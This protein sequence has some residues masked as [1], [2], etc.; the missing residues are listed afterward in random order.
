M[1][2]PLGIGGDDRKGKPHATDLDDSDDDESDS[3]ASILSPRKAKR[4]AA[5]KLKGALD[6]T[7]EKFDA[8]MYLVKVHQNTVI[9]DLQRGKTNVEVKVT[10]RQK[11]LEFLVKDN[12][13][14][15]MICKDAVDNIYVTISGQKM[16]NSAKVVDLATGE[17]KDLFN[18]SRAVFVPLLDRQVEIDRIK[19][20]LGILKR[21]QFIFN[22]PRRMR[23]NIARG[24][25]S[26]VVLNYK[27]VRSLVATASHASIKN[28]VGEVDA[29]V[30]ELHTTLFEDLD[31]P[32]A[33]LRQQEESIKLLVDLGSPIDPAWYALDLRHSRMKAILIE[34]ALKANPVPLESPHYSLSFAAQQ[35]RNTSSIISTVAAILQEHMPQ[36][37]QLANNFFSRSYHKS[38][39]EKKKNAL[40]LK[41]PLGDFLTKLHEIITLFSDIVIKAFYGNTARTMEEA[42][43]LE[44]RFDANPQLLHHVL[45]VVAPT[46]PT[47]IVTGKKRKT[48]ARTNA[49]RTSAS[50]DAAVMPLNRQFAHAQSEAAIGNSASSSSNSSSG[51]APGAAGTGLSQ[52]SGVVP[53]GKN[54]QNAAFTSQSAAQ[55]TVPKA[56]GTIIASTTV[57]TPNA[58]GS[59]SLSFL[60]IDEPLYDKEKVI[61]ILKLYQHLTSISPSAWL[62]PLAELLDLVTR[63]FVKEVFADVLMEAKTWYAQ[64]DWLV[65]DQQRMI[66]SLPFTF[67]SALTSTL[68]RLDGIISPQDPLLVF[69]KKRFIQCIECY[70]D[71]IHH[72]AFVNVDTVYMPPAIRSH[73]STRGHH[74]NDKEEID[75]DDEHD[76]FNSGRYE[77]PTLT[78]DARLLML[79]NN[80]IY[81]KKHI[82]PALIDKFEAQYGIPLYDARARDGKELLERL[83]DMII[84]K[85]VSRKTRILNEVIRSGII[86]SGLDWATVQ[87][88][89]NGIRDYVMTALL[90]LVFIHD[91]LHRVSRVLVRPVLTTVLENIYQGFIDC[92][93]YVDTISN[94]GVLQIGMELEFLSSVMRKYKSPIANGLTAELEYVLQYNSIMDPKSDEVLA[95]DKKIVKG[96]VSSKLQEA[97]LLI[98]CFTGR[99]ANDLMM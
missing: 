2:D 62:E 53:D 90:E 7:D 31:Q 58:P 29:I 88:P 33:T 9:Q 76:D 44:T 4:M 23:D 79:L 67:E 8:V 14:R 20:V 25:Y 52:S 63:T 60:G 99:D 73:P 38:L 84:R 48:Q 46:G 28:V 51:S 64:E 93:N 19:S 39:S 30:R 61:A 91:E 43:K 3:A 80:S 70:A 96:I 72:L 49:H 97:S 50:V 6:P 71:N 5:R 83:E 55:L 26:K 82:L 68:D 37:L 40:A 66:T 17:F 45:P 85:Y 11:Q 1:E 81:T 77:T 15:F 21:S 57:A 41:H 18:R 35:S 10:S 13:S 95:K 32:S 78:D 89:P 36:F 47:I 27:K 54:P 16:N 87:A 86:F 69:I 94:H 22:L 24:E 56:G 12:F 65:L 75:S 42:A 98:E 59:S 34:R 92:L 74:H